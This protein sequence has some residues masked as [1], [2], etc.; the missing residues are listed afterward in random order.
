MMD[1]LKA[2]EIDENTVGE[3]VRALKDS[4]RDERAFR[5]AEL[6]R[7]R[8]RDSELQSRL[9]RAYEDRLDGVIDEAYWRRVSASWREEQDGAARQIQRLSQTSRGYVDQA[10]EIL[11]LSRMAY[12]QYLE[13]EMK[14]KRKL[15]QLLLSN[16]SSNGVS[17]SPTYK[18]PFNLIAEGRQKQFKLPVCNPLHNPSPFVCQTVSLRNSTCYQ[19]AGRSGG[20]EAE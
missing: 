1:V 4:H 20:A 6:L 9:D 18:T 19:R 2:V 16:C 7:L 8:K 10:G 13:R 3:I 5:D 12:S 14:E 15:L 17:L 11:E